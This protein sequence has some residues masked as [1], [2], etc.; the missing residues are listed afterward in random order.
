MRLLRRFRSLAAAERR[1]LIET[2]LLLAAIRIALPLVSF[3]MLQDLLMRFSRAKGLSH[4]SGPLPA[5]RLRWAIHAASRY[6]PQTRNCLIQ[7][8]AAWTLL[9]RRRHPA[10]LR[11]GV[12]N[13]PDREFKAHA[14]VEHDGQVVIGALPELAAYTPLVPGGPP[15]R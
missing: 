11:L 4:T 6:V 9:A 5:D 1:L 10:H 2:A 13:G 8:L 14:W 12:A 3:K 7:A 15:S